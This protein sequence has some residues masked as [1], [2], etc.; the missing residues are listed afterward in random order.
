MS[1]LIRRFNEG[2]SGIALVQL[3][4]LA[5]VIMLF[6]A[7]AVD[8][9]WFYLNANKIQRAADN[10]ALAGVVY[11]PDQGPIAIDRASLVA[12]ANGYQNG[13][14]GASLTIVPQP[15]G[16]KNQLEVTVTDVVDTFFLRV[17]GRDTQTISRTG[18]AEYIKPLPM[19]SP[20]SRFG[21]DGQD[22]I[23]CSGADPCFWAN[24]HGPFTNTGMGDAFSPYCRYGTGYGADNDP[25]CPEGQDH[26][27]S[28]GY[29]YGIDHGGGAFGIQVQNGFFE[30]GG[31][32]GVRAGDNFNW[33]S[34]PCPELNG[35]LTRFRVYK[36][37]ATPLTLEP[38]GLICS[39]NLD[40]MPPPAD[41]T[42]YDW[43]T[44]CS[45]GAPE[46][47]LY[48]VEVRIIDDPVDPA[49]NGGLNRYSIRATGGA[50]LSALGDMSIFN[51]IVGTTEFFLAQVDD[52]YAGRTFVVELYDPGDAQEGVSN[53]I[54]LIGPDGSTWT[55]GCDISKREHLTADFV[56]L[57][58]DAPG[59]G[60]DVDAT[61][62]TFN[63][64]GDWLRI[65]VDL[66]EA[67][68][69]ASCWWKIRYEYSGS[70]ADTTT[71]RAYISGSP[72]RL[73][74]GG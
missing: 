62:P 8:L 72:V 12:E 58:S 13:A 50:K 34:G 20:Q 18:R 67:Y 15:D 29:L 23:D 55:G 31:S 59:T 48:T 21:N 65:E 63:Y 28:R 73:V 41:V 25:G 5:I 14:D 45:V 74:L 3:A 27:T 70:T 39:V 46:P 66:P 47:G 37:D 32:D 42:A 7:F 57:E 33:C 56:F 44:I 54:T 64:D 10:A 30:Q 1:D 26:R 43:T 24:I 4:F 69:C 49:D 71:W 60:C 36:P 61:R 11:M 52:A 16:K 19:G 68:S 53:V 35:P 38:S 6:T 2:E 17:I 9:G 51:N 22:G 40:P